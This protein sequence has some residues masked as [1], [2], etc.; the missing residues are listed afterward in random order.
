VGSNFF[1]GWARLVVD[2]FIFADWVWQLPLALGIPLWVGA[3]L[4]GAYAVARRPRLAWRR[5]RQTLRVPARLDNGTEGGKEGFD[6]ASDQG[7]TKRTSV[8]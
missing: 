5:L 6:S 2:L 8:R 3:F 4:G 1:V 7:F